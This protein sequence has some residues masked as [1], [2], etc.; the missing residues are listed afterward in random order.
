MGTEMDV[1]AVG[2]YVLYKE[3]QDEALKKIMRRVMNWIKNTVLLGLSFGICVCLLI[4][5]I[6]LFAEACMRQAKSGGI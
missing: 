6:G 3:Q 2:N 1:L 4:V 5:E